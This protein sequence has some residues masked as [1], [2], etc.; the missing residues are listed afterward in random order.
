MSE[1]YLFELLA[2]CLRAGVTIRVMFEGLYGT[3]QITK[4][5]QVARIRTC[6]QLAAFI[7]ESTSFPTRERGERGIRQRTAFL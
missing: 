4:P 3:H 1:T 5:S 2:R 7:V 6:R